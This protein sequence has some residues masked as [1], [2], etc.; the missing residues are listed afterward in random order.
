MGGLQ[1]KSSC[2]CQSVDW[3]IQTSCG[4]VPPSQAGPQQQ[5]VLTADRGCAGEHTQGTPHPAISPHLPEVY[6]TKTIVRTSSSTHSYLQ[7]SH[8]QRLEVIT[9]R[10]NGCH[11]GAGLLC[12]PAC[13]HAK[14][15]ASA[16]WS[17]INSI[18]QALNHTT[19][20]IIPCVS[21]EW[22]HAPHA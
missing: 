14:R 9:L 16:T 5:P 11:F 15:A 13:K 8:Q 12:R 7:R 6:L 20:H 19:S 1:V 2:S 21:P 22:R 4:S 18:F 17:A 3:I 10:S